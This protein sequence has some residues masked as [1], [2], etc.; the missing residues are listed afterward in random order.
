MQ[1]PLWQPP[2]DLSEQEEQPI[3]WRRKAKLF[4]FLRQHRHELLNEEF[5]Q[6]GEP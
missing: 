1:P 5:Q 3:K 6:E 4:M 2:G